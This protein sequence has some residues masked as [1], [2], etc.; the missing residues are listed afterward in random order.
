MMRFLTF[1]VVAF[2]MLHLPF[3]VCNLGSTLGVHLC[4]KFTFRAAITLTYVNAALNP[5]LY[6]LL[7][8]DCAKCSCSWLTNSF[9]CAPIKCMLYICCPSRDEFDD[10]NSLSDDDDDNYVRARPANVA[11]SQGWHRESYPCFVHDIASERT[12]LFLSFTFKC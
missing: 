7:S 3:W 2:W 10:S 4:S 8:T 5:F 6:S 9:L 11:G 12:F 1:V